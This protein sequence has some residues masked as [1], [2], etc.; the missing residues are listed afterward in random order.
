MIRGGSVSF[1]D[2][3]DDSV[4]LTAFR[5]SA[6]TNNEAWDAGFRCARPEKSGVMPIAT[7]EFT[8]DKPAPTDPPAPTST[9]S[10]GT[11]DPNATP[12]PAGTSNSIWIPIA[13]TFGDVIMDYIPAGCFYMGTD[14]PSDPDFRNES[15]RLRVCLTTPYWFD[16]YEVTNGQYKRLTGKLLSIIADVG[17]PVTPISWNDADAFC[18]LRGGQLPT[19]AQW[20]YAARGTQNFIFPWGDNF[21]AASE[22][23]P[24]FTIYHGGANPKNLSWIGAFD[25]S[26]NVMEW[27]SDWYAPDAYQ[28]SAINDPRGPIS[29][30]YRVL[31]GGSYRGYA[32]VSRHGAYRNFNR[33]D[34]P[35]SEAGIRCIRP[36]QST[37]TTAVTASP[38]ILTLTPTS[39]TPTAAPSTP[40]PTLI[41]AGTSNTIWTPI[42]S[43]FK[44]I[45]MQRVPAGCFIMGDVRENPYSIPKHEV[46]ITK[47]FWIDQTEVT[48]DTLPRVGKRDTRIQEKQLP[49]SG[50][51]WD[52]ARA[53]C[54]MRG[55]NLP[56]EAQ[57][58]YAAQGPE[59]LNYPWGNEDD[60]DKE[61]VSLDVSYLDTSSRPAPVGSKPA[62]ASWVG[63]MDMS[64]NVAEWAMDWYSETYDTNSPKNDPPGPEHGT[65][66]VVLG[67]GYRYIFPVMLYSLFEQRLNIPPTF[68]VDLI[69][70]RCILPDSAKPDT[71]P[72][73]S[74]TPGK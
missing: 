60:P 64:G 21:D 69:G 53:F 74:P 39:A 29:G 55:G 32:E 11:I 26:E 40:I 15:P 61:V 30:E 19:E 17:L 58:E 6:E 67:G 62:G 44:G 57:W 1:S 45:E 50:I 13:E 41:P 23:P 51:T 48:N 24:F 3:F 5:M 47:P 7:A 37:T 49:L 28:Q 71:L 9:P 73:A 54:I 8:P 34:V 70:F 27:V 36:I 56:T 42:T 25:L 43:T 31:R 20:E 22:D 68:R 14:N 46:C 63:A 33:P 18:K 35:A 2:S 65:E 16:Q 12:I 59:S 4:Y 72:L 10:Q 38:S 52:E 66:R